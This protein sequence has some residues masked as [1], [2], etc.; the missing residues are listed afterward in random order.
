[1]RDL[2]VVGIGLQVGGRETC[3]ETVV[4]LEP[5]P[6]DL[7]SGHVA[8]AQTLLQCVDHRTVIAHAPVNFNDWNRR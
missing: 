6:Q 4:M 5:S 2:Q 1:M 3:V 7:V 8:T